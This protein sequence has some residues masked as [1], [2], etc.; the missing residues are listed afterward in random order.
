MN[1]ALLLALIRN[2]LRLFFSDRRA[3]LSTVLVPIA[4]ASF[5]ATIF[6]GPEKS[7]AKKEGISV[8]VTDSDQSTLSKK[9]LTELKAD[10]ELSVLESSEA[11]A[12]QKVR[13]GKIG[14][15]LLLPKNFGQDASKAMFSPTAP[16]PELTLITDPSKNAEV[17]MVRGLLLQHVMQTASQSAFSGPTAAQN[18]DEQLALLNASGQTDGALPEM[19][20]SVRKYMGESPQANNNALAMRSPCTIREES[21]KAAN[22]GEISQRTAIRIHAF[23]GMAVQ[24]LLFYAL[25]SAI[26]LLRERRSGIW[27]RLRAA[28]LARVTLLL[29]RMLSIMLVGLAVQSVIFGVGALAFGLRVT[30]SAIGFV[31]LMLLTA[32]MTAGFGLVIAALGKTEAQSRAFSVPAVLALSVLGGAWFPSFLLPAWVKN[33]SQFIPTRWAIDGFDAMTWRGLGFS[34]AVQPA[35]IL[36]GFATAFA[37]FAYTRFRWEE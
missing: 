7:D 25:D 30:G 35:L 12:R 37:I 11:D 32:L 15:A 17:Q 23:I 3:M 19:L 2:D 31:L 24:G 14:V 10:T 20:K 33:I 29:G 1:L 22:T 8:L 26:G 13:E 27:R 21:A 4:M 9:I 6:G 18:I 34:H 5:F 36:L 16:V 28:P